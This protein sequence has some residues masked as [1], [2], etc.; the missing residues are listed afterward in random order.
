MAVPAHDERDWAF[1]KK[2]NIPIRRVIERPG[3]IGIPLEEAYSEL[4]I[5]VE[6]GEFTGLSSEEAKEK[7][8]ALAEK[9]GFGEGKIQYR[10]RDWLVS[11]QR[12]WGCP[13]PMIYCPSCG[14]VP[15]A[16]EALPVE[17]P[18]SVDLALTSETKGRSPL[19]TVDDFVNTLCPKCGG[20]AERETDTMDTFVCSSWYY[21]RFLDPHNTEKPFDPELAKRWMPVDQYVG[22]IEHA[23][24]HLMYSRFFMMALH[25]GDWTDGDEPFSRLLTQGMVLKDG[26]KMSKSK[27]N[28]VD[29]DDIL[30][31]FGA[32]TARFF[33]L[34]DSPPQADFDWKDTGVEGCFKFLQ[35]V[36]RVTIDH[37]SA[38]QLDLPLPAYD[39]MSEAHR[40]LY[41]LTHKTISGVSRDIEQGFQ[42]NT[43][44][45]KLREFVNFLTRYKLGNEPD[46]V[47]SHAVANLLRLMAP[48]TVHQ[49]EEI[50][51]KLG[52]EGSIHSQAWPEF[53]ESALVADVIE[54]VF[55]V[56]GKVREKAQVEPNL[57]KGQLE[58]MAKANEKVQT[59]LEGKTVVKTIV[60]PNKLVNIVV[61]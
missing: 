61:K 35:R 21:L 10:L 14:E 27:G 22:G 30:S 34:S 56:N 32:D 33:I 9:E 7:I 37:K 47:F 51:Q 16:D 59:F 57:S 15:V 31:E 44:I 3:A 45:S 23:I 25:D 6:S 42:F 24:L 52:G 46:P 11:R 36:W 41:Q 19:A 26:S 29:P 12:Y 5:L 49:S 54:I 40:E 1:A 43:I 28:V 17:L 55:Q 38:I 8:T 2:Y 48:I 4:G 50:W 13:I 18:E 60:I 53:D 39:T 20:K 58:S